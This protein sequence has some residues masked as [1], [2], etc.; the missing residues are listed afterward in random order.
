[1]LGRIL[2]HEH[3]VQIKGDSYRLRKQK[4]AG[5]QGSSVKVVAQNSG[6]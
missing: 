6:A 5:F 4:K 2:H 1:M 3:I